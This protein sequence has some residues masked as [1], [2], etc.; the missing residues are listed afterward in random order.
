[1][2]L[3]I[4]T[5]LSG[6]TVMAIGLGSANA[7]EPLKVSD[8]CPTYWEKDS[9]S[10]PSPDTLTWFDC[11]VK[12]PKDGKTALY[13]GTP[14][15]ISWHND[16]RPDWDREDFEAEALGFYLDCEYGPREWKSHQR[17]HLTMV[18][19]APII[20][21]GWHKGPAGRTFGLRV[22]RD[23]APMAP[24]ILFPEPLLETTTLEGVGLGWTYE[25]L[26]AF[27][28]R[29]G[30]TL[31]GWYG[32]ASVGLYRPGLALEVVFDPKIQ[33]SRQVVL[34]A[35]WQ[36]E[37][38]IALRRYAVRRFGFDWIH[39]DGDVEKLWRSADRQIE[40]EFD[41]GHRPAESASLRLIDKRPAEALR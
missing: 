12:W 27:A 5:I 10:C 14:R 6:L 37:D 36:D 13:F 32:E 34:R 39:G 41:S 17:V 20:Q 16:A 18:I 9:P 40:L 7:S 4:A 3:F 31:Q 24:E 38:I 19:P 23:T 2:R 21:Y 25:E 29:G 26:K 8:A 1:M 30:F 15:P 11:P 35:G 33:K 28:K 22:S